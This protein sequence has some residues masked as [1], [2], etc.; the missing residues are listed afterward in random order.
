[1]ANRQSSGRVTIADVAARV[2][3][4]SMT[5]SRVLN[6]DPR[7]RPET[8]QRVE[9]AIAELRYQPNPAAR[10]LAGG[11]G[12]RI[13]LL[14]ANPSAGYLGELLLGALEAAGRAGAQLVVERTP[15]DVEPEALAA[16]IGHA[17]DA[18][19]APPPLSDRADVRA[20]AHANALPAAFLSAGAEPGAGYDV[21]IDDRA[22]ARE[23][24]A[25]LIGL[26]H[27][28]IAFIIGHPNQAVSALRLEGYRDAMREAGLGTRGDWIAQGAFTTR[29]GVDAAARLLDGD[30]RP[31]A[32]FA[33]NDDMAAGVLAEAARRG[34]S[35]PGDLSVMGFDDSPLATTVWPPLTTIEQPVAAMADE[36][37]TWLLAALPRREASLAPSETRL[38]HRIIVRESTGPAPV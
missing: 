18:V 22:A 32:V 4:S 14:Y 3:V 19:I 1:M 6:R 12:P 26:G 17:W 10:H 20:M 30:H 25:H 16:R 24:T 9:T 13:G 36:A 38:A 2:G 5:V 28:A 15:L 37:V 27:R 29:S 8:R 31:T 34:L 21:R 23:G 11:V 35:A 7:V 33:S